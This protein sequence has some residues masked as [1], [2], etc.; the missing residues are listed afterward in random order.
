MALTAYEIQRQKNIE[1]NRLLLEELG[2][3]TPFFPK[4]EKPKKKPAA[5]KKRK[6]APAVEDNAEGENFPVKTARVSSED[7]T[8]T[9]GPRRSARNAGKK[10]DYNSEQLAAAARPRMISLK[11]SDSTMESDPR[12]GDRR[13]HDP[14]TYGSIPGIDVGT[15]WET[16]QACSVDA[17]HAPWV[18]GIAPGPKGAFSVA[19]SGGYEDDVDLGYGFTYTGSGGRDLKGTKAAPKNL[20]TAPQSSDQTFENNFNA[21]LK[22]SC[23]TKNPVRVIRGFKLHSQFAPAEGYRYDGLYTI[24]K[25][26]LEKGLNPHGYLVCKFAFKRLPGQPPIPTKDGSVRAQSDKVEKAD[27]TSESD[28]EEETKAVLKE[29]EEEGEEENGKE[30]ND[31]VVDVANS[32]GSATPEGG[33]GS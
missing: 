22:K 25:A 29:N 27:K 32:E 9:D 23:E 16:R 1:S 21:A 33:E 12:R 13:I 4:E 31:L 10:V 2:L 5:P 6:S 15:W 26:W 19:L 8:G 3:E 30:R 17:I 20:R 28:D 11:S 14:R 18:A 24:E 7:V